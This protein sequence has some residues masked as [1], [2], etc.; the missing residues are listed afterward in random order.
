MTEPE[1]VPVAFLE[2]Y[3]VFCM[4]TRIY[5]SWESLSLWGKQFA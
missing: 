1:N 5:V 2:Y 3:S 4:K